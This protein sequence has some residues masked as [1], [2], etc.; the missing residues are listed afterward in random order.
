MWPQRFYPARYFTGRYW[1][2]VGEVA[3]PFHTEGSAPSRYRL[4][5]RESSILRAVLVF[6]ALR[7][8]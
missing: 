6:L 2:K 3:F 4:R 8:L 7:L 5:Y 1:A